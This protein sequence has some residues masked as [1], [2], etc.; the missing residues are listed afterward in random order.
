MPSSSHHQRHH[1]HCHPGPHLPTL[2]P[3][4]DVV[5][6]PVV[7]VVA[8]AQGICRTSQ[9]VS[10]CSRSGLGSSSFLLTNLQMMR[11]ASWPCSLD[12]SPSTMHA[13]SSSPSSCKSPTT[14]FFV[15]LGRRSCCACSSSVSSSSSSQ[16]L[17]K[18]QLTGD[19]NWLAGL[20]WIAGW[21]VSRKRFGYD[22]QLR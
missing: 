9:L 2:L 21:L 19:L 11:P 15:R 10:V 4:S 5:S 22:I 16:H 13:V 14:L 1:C 17:T 8:S 3:L 12:V 7:S 18:S 20:G 6:V